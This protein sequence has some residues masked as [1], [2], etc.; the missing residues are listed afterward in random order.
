VPNVTRSATSLLF[1][2][3]DVT[4]GGYEPKYRCAPTAVQQPTN[5]QRATGTFGFV[6]PTIPCHISKLFRILQI[7][8]CDFLVIQSG[9]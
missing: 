3:F 1:A 4:A 6:Y 7:V 9:L 8:Q 2:A 5:F